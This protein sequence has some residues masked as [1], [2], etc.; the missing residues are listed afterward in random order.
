MSSAG[1]ERSMEHRAVPTAHHTRPWRGGVGKEDQQEELAARELLKQV[2]FT[3][4]YIIILAG[5]R[6]AGGVEL[7]LLTASGGACRDPAQDV[8]VWGLRAAEMPK[9]FR[10]GERSVFYTISCRDGPK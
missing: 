1:W 7:P 8:A 6:G 4:I 5:P 2:L 3:Q 10:C 9:E